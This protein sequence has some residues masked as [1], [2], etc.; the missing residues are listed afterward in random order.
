LLEDMSVKQA[1]VD[2]EAQL[3][4]GIAATQDPSWNCALPARTFPKQSAGDPL[5]PDDERAI[6][7]SWLSAGCP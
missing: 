3:R 4:C 1:W 7:V 6:M 2:R 5:P